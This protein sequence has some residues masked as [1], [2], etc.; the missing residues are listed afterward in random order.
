MSTLRVRR[1]NRRGTLRLGSILR[2]R[3][4]LDFVELWQ[5]H[6]KTPVVALRNRSLLLFHAN[7]AFAGHRNNCV[8]HHIHVV[9]G[10]PPT[11]YIKGSKQ[12]V[13][14]ARFKTGKALYNH[15]VR[16]YGPLLSQTD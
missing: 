3:V 15:V 7:C 13:P 10:N 6:M 8:Q 16:H 9:P 5:H 4:T 2:H 1:N 12:P 14:M 11:I